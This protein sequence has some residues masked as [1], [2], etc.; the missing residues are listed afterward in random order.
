MKRIRSIPILLLLLTLILVSCK[1]FLEVEAPFTSTSSENVYDNDET[2]IAVMT[3]V[4]AYLSSNNGN[5]PVNVLSNLSLYCGLYSDELELFDKNNQ[6][7]FPY[8]TNDLSNITDPNFWNSIYHVV[9]VTNTLTEGVANSKKLSDPVKKQL[10]GEGKFMRAYCYFYLVNLY[11]K[12]PLAITSDYKVNATSSRANIENVFEQIITDLNDAINLLSDKFLDASLTNSSEDRVRPTKWAAMALLSKVYLFTQNYMASKDLATKVIAHS[13]LFKLE[14][15]SKTFL[16]NSKETIW[17]LQNVGTADNSNTGDARIFILP[18]GGP[19]S[20]DNPVVLAPVLLQRFEN[21]D[22][23]RQVWIDSTIIGSDKF[24]YSFKYKAGRLTSQNVESL[25]LFRLAE[26]YLLRAEAEVQLTDYS[27]A[28]SDLDLIRKRA[29]LTTINI[30]DKEKLLTA[31]FNEKQV[32]LFTE[33]GARWI[34][35]KHFNKA[36][37]IMPNIVSQKGGNWDTKSLLFPIPLSELEA[38][39]NLIQNPGY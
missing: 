30:T 31:I 35:V 7:L 11:G 21:G 6:A 18:D 23:R 17:C 5:I 37:I 1:K 38:N 27:S 20:G 16:K 24:Y 39:S 22:L 3:D 8:Y 36:D 14:D 34:D 33:M 26:L 25:V 2:A 13:E 4:Y 28:N 19:N 10:L 32:E 29:G 9:Y 12:V 15:L